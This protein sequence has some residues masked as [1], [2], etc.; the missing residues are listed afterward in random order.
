MNRMSMGRNLQNFISKNLEKRRCVQNLVRKLIVKTK[1]M[2]D[3]KK[4]Q[5]ISKCF[6]KHSSNKTLRKL[7]S[8]NNNSLIL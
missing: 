4:H 8:K 2:T 7:M 5:I 6:M 3:P 1:E